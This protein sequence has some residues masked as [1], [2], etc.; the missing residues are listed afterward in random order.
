MSNKEQLWRQVM[1]LENSTI[2]QAIQILNETP[3]KIVLVVNDKGI[4]TGTISDGDIRRGL[5]RDLDLASSITTVV[6]RDP[7]VVPRELSQDLIIQLMTVNKIRQIPIV[8]KELRVV[9]LH[10]WDSIHSIQVRSNLMVIMAGGKGTRLQPQTNNCP[11]PLLKIHGKPILEHIINRA[12]IEGFRNFIISIHYLGHMIE[13]YFGNGEKFGVK[14]E[15]L[16]EETPL[17]TAG[18][19]SQ[20]NPKPK[21]PFVVTNGDIITDIRYGK[22]L[23]FHQNQNAQATMAIRTLEMQNPYGVVET[24]G[25]EI[26]GFE[27]KPKSYSHI[28]A[29]V[30]VIDPKQLDLLKKLTPYDMPEFFELI[31]DNSGKIIAYP[32]HENWL[33]VGSPHDLKW[34]NNEVLF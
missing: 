17:G 13:E 4:L 25:I 12:K 9:G 27:E 23:E 31:R 2:G 24:D 8:D 21:T 7:L 28:N 6:H 22:L 18:A 15:Y 19:L 11:K 16:K 33:D 30:Y 29:G 26:I 1:L 3:F 5:L 34:V 14:I 32:S 10:S 20:L